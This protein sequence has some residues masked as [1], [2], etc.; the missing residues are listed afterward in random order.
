MIESGLSESHNA[1]VTT[2]MPDSDVAQVPFVDQSE[3]FGM[4]DNPILT[5]M[6]QCNDTQDSPLTL[7]PRERD[8]ASTPSLPMRSLP[9][10]VLGQTFAMWGCRRQP[11]C[12]EEN[13]YRARSATEGETS[14]DGL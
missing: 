3:Q 7:V 1:F 12:I 10:W 2:F 5:N 8:A 6:W 4:L 14:E 13:L 11:P 9:R